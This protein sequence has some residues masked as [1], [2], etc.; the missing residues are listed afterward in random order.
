MSNFLKD[1]VVRS[2][3]GLVIWLVFAGCVCANTR[4]VRGSDAW[5]A[6]ELRP[7][8]NRKTEAEYPSL[9]KLYEYLH[10]H[11]E[12]SLHEKE[13]SKRLAEQL[14]SCGFEVTENIGGYGV[15]G[16][17]RNGDG[18]TVLVRTD[19]DALPIEEKTGLSYA[20]KVKTIDA[21]GRKV[22]VMHACGHDIHMTIFTGVGRLMSSWRHKW[23]GTVV[24]IG[25]PAEELA[26]GARA[27]LADGLFER[28]PKPDYLLGLHIMDDI[29]AGQ[30]GFR[31]GYAMARVDSVDITVRGVGGHGAAPQQTKDPVVIAAEI[32]LSLQTIVS[33]EVSPFEPAVVTVGQ[34]HGGT[35]RNIIGDEVKM[36]LTVRSYQ[37]K[38]RNKILSAIKRISKGIGQAAGVSED[39]LPIVYV[40]PNPCPPLYNSPELVR[41]V[42]AAI[43]RVI[44]DENVKLV[45]RKTGGEDFAVYRDQ[46]PSISSYMFFVGCISREKL[47]QGQEATGLQPKLH[48]P[49][50]TTDAE[51]TIKTGIK[52]MSAAVL[53][54]LPT[55]G[56][57]KRYLKADPK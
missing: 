48:S 50:M 33:R 9:Q 10:E 39:K 20:S 56:N 41:R 27:M 17:L 44:G 16:V 25:Q 34:I 5:C 18:P 23:Q 53:E 52:A 51:P 7:E 29:A 36:E 35:K 11:P 54:L 13:T 2:S 49:Y 40:Q 24:M 45:G 21:Q 15:V 30:I 1:F 26:A 55:G 4:A 14:R 8:I 6:E 37:E 42:N 31:A 22:G 46:Y 57:G 28:F 3:L 19:M 43:G 12:L 32:I 38:T 47:R